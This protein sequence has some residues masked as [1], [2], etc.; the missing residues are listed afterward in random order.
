MN[1]SSVASIGKSYSLILAEESE[2]YERAI[3]VKMLAIPLLV[4]EGLWSKFS[5]VNIVKIPFSKTAGQTTS[6]LNTYWQPS[7]LV[8]SIFPTHGHMKCTFYVE[9]INLLIGAF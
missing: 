4:A 5:T 2:L 7:P 9:T 1:N 6:L 3:C 8:A